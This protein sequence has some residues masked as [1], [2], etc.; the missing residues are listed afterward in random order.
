MMKLNVLMASLRQRAQDV[1]DHSEPNMP[2][3]GYYASISFLLWAVV[4]VWMIPQPYENLG[5]RVLESVLA[6]PLIFY[7]SLPGFLRKPFPF[8]F[9]FYTLF[10]CPFFFFFMTMK[11]EW[12]QVWTTTALGGLMV[13]IVIAYDWLFITLFM[14][15]AYL[16]AY[17]TVMLQDGAVRY[18]HLDWTYMV[19]FVFSVSGVMV[20]TRWMRSYQEMRFTIL[21]SLGG[22]IAHEM[23][24]AL[25]AVALGIESVRSHLPMKP[26]EAAEG[27][28][29]TVIP[30]ASLIRIYDTINVGTDTIQ[31]ADKVIE[32]ILWSLT[33]KRIDQG[34]FRQLTAAGAIRSALDGYVFS[35]DGERSFVNVDDSYDFDFLADQDLFSSLMTNLL[36]NALYYRYVDGFR[37][38]ISTKT[39]ATGN[40]IVFR[41][42]GPGI[43]PDR[44]ERVFQ[45][46]YTYGKP[47]GNGIG[48]AYCRR[49]VSSF[50]GR[51][52]CRSEVGRWTEFVIDL[53]AYDTKTV[54]FLKY[55]ILGDK[56]VLIVDDQ[57][58]NRILLK[59]V[60]SDM[61]CSC[62]QAVNGLVAIE[63]ARKT[64]YDLILM[65]IEMPEL[66]G[67]EAVYRLRH[68]IGIKSSFAQHY[69]DVPIVGI[70]A[71]PEEEGRR[72]A[73][74]SG[75]DECLFKPIRKQEIAPVVEKYFFSERKAKATMPTNI[76]MEGTILIV[77]DNMV[78]R[79]FLK[80]MLE[81][82]G[83][84]VSQAEN[85]K[86]ALEL[87]ETVAP[88]LIIMDMEM[89]VMDGIEASRIIRAGESPRLLRS[90]QIPII[91]LSGYTDKDAVIAA[92][93]T[94]INCYLG[95]PVRKQDLVKAI[96]D[97]LYQRE[98][99]HQPEAPTDI[100]ACSTWKEIECV[101]I[102]D[103]SAI[104]CLR[105][106]GDEEFMA[107]LF[108]LF[109]EETNRIIDD[110]EDACGKQDWPR[111]IRANHTMKGS[112]ANIGASRIL[113]MTTRISKA[114][115]E[116]RRPAEDDWTDY[117]RKVCRLT[118]EALSELASI[119]QSSGTPQ[120]P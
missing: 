76:K 105:E 47:G 77:E 13:I 23:R 56:K 102:L 83:L 36:H 25:N 97:I 21:K 108:R 92:R 101:E 93:E 120:E 95:K 99:R 64:R 118:G 65:D 94:D 1:L 16:A 71:L 49:I 45:P 98:V 78:S 85:G 17:A 113:S 82:L 42:S 43:E 27:R 40:R 79:E 22:T 35:S 18:T 114:L 55:E 15:L 91:M 39:L 106:L 9:L 10:T 6:L 37:I 38:D 70:T 100:P 52:T 57:P 69:I 63:M 12:S 29:E 31:Q 109:I 107:N 68:G 34:Q 53:P 5:F 80:A 46:F 19:S 60:L 20:A 117:L 66:N 33:G 50:S 67:D 59:K 14:T 104:E 28:Q 74:G 89:P 84:K 30:D 116:G 24:N 111:A 32:S 2:A 54:E 87:L 96:S 7:R 73:W 41:D 4:L 8:Y 110:L 72:R 11:N 119:K 86:R 62:D 81:S 75:M 44:L 61:N 115:H 26:T 3:L 112:A 103:L 48:L 51:I 58:A 88:D 90:R